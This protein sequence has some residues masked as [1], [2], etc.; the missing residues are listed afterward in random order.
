M[1]YRKSGSDADMSRKPWTKYEFTISRSRV[2]PFRPST[3]YCILALL[4][5]VD[6]ITLLLTDTSLANDYLQ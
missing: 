2:L 5:V 6:Y 3:S 1:E 4:P